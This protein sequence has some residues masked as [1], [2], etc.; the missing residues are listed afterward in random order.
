ML[1]DILIAIVAGVVAGIILLFV[2][3][4]LKQKEY[5]QAGFD[6]QTIDNYRRNVLLK[7]VEEHKTYNDLNDEE[8]TVLEDTKLKVLCP[9]CAEHIQPYS[10]VCHHCKYEFETNAWDYNINVDKLKMYFTYA[11]GSE[12]ETFEKAE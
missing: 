3:Q 8:L 11:G 12:I 4:L 9:K 10:L 6:I 1:N 7:I 2:K 5:E